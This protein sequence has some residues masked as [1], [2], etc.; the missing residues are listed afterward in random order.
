MITK[1]DI[2]LMLLIV[3]LVFLSA[4]GTILLMDHM[5]Y[6]TTGTPQQPFLIVN[7]T[8]GIEQPISAE[9]YWQ[10]VFPS[11]QCAGVSINNMIRA[12]NPHRTGSMRPYL[13]AGDTL[14]M[15]NYDPNK[16]L[17]LG[18]V[19]SV[20][21]KYL[22]RIIAISDKDQ[23]YWTKGDN[24]AAKDRFPAHFNETTTVVCGVLRGT[25]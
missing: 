4:V 9:N 2:I 18:D 13:Y 20:S 5:H 21:G 7:S 22:H 23:I 15:V 3:A 1:E 8:G 12:K 17:V 16:P 14:L 25:V 10:N 6:R 24:N 11:E 19:V